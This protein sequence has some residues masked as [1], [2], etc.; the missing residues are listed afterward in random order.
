MKYKGLKSNCKNGEIIDAGV[1]AVVVVVAAAKRRAGIQAIAVNAMAL[2]IKN[3]PTRWILEEH[4]LK[5]NT[6]AGT[7]FKIPQVPT[8]AGQD[9]N[10]EK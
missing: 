8:Q 5:I 9:I 3:I 6:P 7:L 4:L 2:T 10:L 1:V